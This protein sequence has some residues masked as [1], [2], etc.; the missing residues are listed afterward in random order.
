MTVNLAAGNGVGSFAMIHDSFGTH[1]A[2]VP[3]LNACLREAFIE[4]Y[5]DND[6][7]AMFRDETQLLTTT[8]LPSLPKK[9]ELDL[10][11]VRESEFFFA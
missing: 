9:G 5:L 2:D 8:A 11:A 10:T 1:A 6:P 3:M 7:L 4:L